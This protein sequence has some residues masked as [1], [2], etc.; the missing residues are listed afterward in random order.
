MQD[1]WPQEMTLSSSD[2]EVRESCLVL[3]CNGATEALCWTRAVTCID[4]PARITL[5]NTRVRSEKRSNQCQP[6]L[7]GSKNLK[8][9]AFRSP[10][11]RACVLLKG[12]S[13]N[14]WGPSVGLR[15]TRR[16]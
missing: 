8:R 6:I 15:D 13:P 4:I 2:H 12:L 1:L 10:L 5:R 14:M 3:D 16:K 9:R 7:P 11:V